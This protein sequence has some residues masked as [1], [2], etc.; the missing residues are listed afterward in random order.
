[1]AVQSVLSPALGAVVPNPGMFWGFAEERGATPMAAA[2]AA[3][4]SDDDSDEA[5]LDRFLG[6]RD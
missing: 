5:V 3:A 1:M 2:A 6:G 4:A